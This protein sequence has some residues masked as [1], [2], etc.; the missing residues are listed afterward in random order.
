MSVE[1]KNEV[2]FPNM[3]QSNLQMCRLGLGLGRPR[4]IK[5]S[6]PSPRAEAGQENIETVHEPKPIQTADAPWGQGRR[7]MRGPH[8]PRTHVRE[9]ARAIKV[10]MSCH[11]AGMGVIWAAGM[12]TDQVRG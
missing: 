10:S 2:M 1:C 5:N 12:R 9:G 7:A 11:D 4:D 8:G 6:P 3:A